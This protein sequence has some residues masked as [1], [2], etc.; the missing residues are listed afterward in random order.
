M[1]FVQETKLGNVDFMSVQRLWGS[2][3]FDF[4][5]SSANGASGGLL[6]IW[7]KASF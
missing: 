6:V 4:A 2:G 7:R 5:F 3:D 1:V